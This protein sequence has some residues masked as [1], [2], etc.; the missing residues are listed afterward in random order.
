MPWISLNT[1]TITAPGNIVQATNARDSAVLTRD[2]YT[3]MAILFQAD[4][5]NA[6]RV[7]I[8]TAG[9]NKTTGVGRLAVLAIPTAN[10]IPSAGATNPI[11]GRLLAA[12][13]Y[14]VD[15]DVMNDKVTVS[16]LVA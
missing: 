11:P 12:T 10:T 5:F 3:C 7:Y 8:G 4:P 6:G 16:I 13:D 2:Y 14:W 1:V 15:A 9:F